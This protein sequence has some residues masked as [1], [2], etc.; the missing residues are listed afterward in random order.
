MESLSNYSD[1]HV[2]KV[3]QRWPERKFCV[4]AVQLLK[5]K[6]ENVEVDAWRMWHVV[7]IRDNL[8]SW[9]T[10]LISD[11][12]VKTRRLVKNIFLQGDLK[13]KTVECVDEYVHKDERLPLLLDR[14]RESGAK[15]FLLTN[16]EYWYTNALMEYLLSYPDKVRICGCCFFPNFFHPLLNHT[17][18]LSSAP[19]N[20]YLKAHPLFT[21]TWS[22]TKIIVY[23]NIIKT[24]KKQQH[25]KNEYF[26]ITVLFWE[27]FALLTIFLRWYYY[28]HQF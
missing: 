7:L 6:Y 19:P 16:S 14:M 26:E 10:G 28:Y 13:K 2:R 5:W 24:L 15:V 22:I 25:T 23:E 17:I 12:D 4:C 8:Q 9:L 18:E 27:N 21:Y 3:S 11:F 20:I 1:I